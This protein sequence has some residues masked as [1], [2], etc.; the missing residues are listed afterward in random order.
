[1]NSFPD[2]SKMSQDS[3]PRFALLH[4]S[5]SKLTDC[6]G[7]ISNRIGSLIVSYSSNQ[8]GV[9]ERLLNHPSPS[10]VHREFPTLRRLKFFPLCPMYSVN[11]KGID[12]CF[13]LSRCTTF[14]SLLTDTSFLVATFVF[15]P[16]NCNAMEFRFRFDL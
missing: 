3:F 14:S 5:S 6:G 7:G 9:R 8:F 16:S 11:P 1:M 2:K 4:I 13:K 12:L 15:S 10:S